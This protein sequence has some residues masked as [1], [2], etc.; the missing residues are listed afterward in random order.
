MSALAKMNV[1]TSH[2]VRTFLQTH[3]TVCGPQSELEIC[4]T[5][6]RPL[7]EES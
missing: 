5:L 6:Q 2:V 3:S 4:L 7:A 1:F